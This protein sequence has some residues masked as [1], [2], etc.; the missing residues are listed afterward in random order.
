M[1]EIEL[2]TGRQKK[3]AKMI[4]SSRKVPMIWSAAKV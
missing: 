4:M 3:P 1:T 2:I